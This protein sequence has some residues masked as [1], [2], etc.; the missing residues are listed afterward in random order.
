[1][2]DDIDLFPD[3]LTWTVNRLKEAFPHVKVATMVPAN[4]TGTLMRVTG[5]GSSPIIR[6]KLDSAAITVE[7][8][9]ENEVTAYAL[10]REARVVLIQAEAQEYTDPLC[11]VSA[12]NDD[13]PL[14]PS[15][16]PDTNMLRYQFGI[17]II[18]KGVPF[19]AS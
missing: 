4:Y 12:V 10:A 7:V 11:W 17:R 16:D 18:G 1:M 3:W 14:V 9:D 6:E 13:A 5:L 15:P 8:W 19:V 2:P